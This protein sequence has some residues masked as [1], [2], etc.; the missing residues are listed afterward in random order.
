MWLSCW[1][2]WIR[3]FHQNN[4]SIHAQI[5]KWASGKLVIPPPVIRFPFSSVIDQLNALGLGAPCVTLSLRNPC[6][7]S[8]SCTLKSTFVCSEL[9]RCGMCANWL[10]DAPRV[11]VTWGF[12]FL[13]SLLGK[14]LLID[15]HHSASCFAGIRA[16]SQTTA[17]LPPPTSYVIHLRLRTRLLM[18]SDPS[19]GVP[20]RASVLLSSLWERL[21]MCKGVS[22]ARV[23]VFTRVTPHFFFLFCFFPHRFHRTGRGMLENQ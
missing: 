2:N 21:N 15:W 13:F 10:Q 1:S 17:F 23:F 20:A 11:S 5:Q 9:L 16:R 19:R 12:Y 22:C 6:L 18:R 8:R 3:L 4:P 7:I 14:H